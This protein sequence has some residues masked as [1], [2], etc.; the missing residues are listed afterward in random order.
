MLL[1]H[2]E[3][4]FTKNFRSELWMSKRPNEQKESKRQQEKIF[5]QEKDMETTWRQSKE[6]FQVIH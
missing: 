2:F 4:S 5:T 6:W 1:E 3:S